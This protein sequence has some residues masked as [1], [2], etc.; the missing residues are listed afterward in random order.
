MPIQ[1]WD[2]AQQSIDRFLIEAGRLLTRCR[3]IDPVFLQF[4]SDEFLRLIIL[5]FIFCSTVLRMHR[6]F[7]VSIVCDSSR[8]AGHSPFHSLSQG[9]TYIPCSH[10]QLPDIDL[11]EHP[12]LK[13]TIHEIALTLDIRSHFVDVDDE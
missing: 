11:I 13:R 4:Y 7:R 5:R 8:Q 12:T 3:N 9:Q 1:I 2:K 6:L 10:P